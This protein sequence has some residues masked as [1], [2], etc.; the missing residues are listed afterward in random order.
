MVGVPMRSGGATFVRSPPCRTCSGIRVG[1]TGTLEGRWIGRE[2]YESS[3]RAAQCS[4]ESRSLA[5][6]YIQL[7]SS[8]ARGRWHAEGMTEGEVTDTSVPCPPP[9]SRLRRA[10][11]PWRGRNC[12]RPRVE[13]RSREDQ[14][15][16]RLTALG[17]PGLLLS[18]EHWGS[19]FDRAR[20]TACVWCARESRFARLHR[21]RRGGGSL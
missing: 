14:A 4:C 17:T 18:Q 8:P 6:I 15:N 9:P 20:V 5:P 1:R 16:P 21:W 3:H 19:D 10:T 2:S 7:N 13:C 11:S 12:H